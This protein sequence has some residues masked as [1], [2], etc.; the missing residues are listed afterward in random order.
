MTQYE[1]RKYQEVD[2]DAILSFM[3]EVISPDE[4]DLKVV[5]NAC[6]VFEGEKVVG[7]VSYEDAEDVGVIR[8]FIYNHYSLPDLLVNMFFSLYA[9]AKTSGV[10][11]LVALVANPYAFQLFELLGFNEVTH[12][13]DLTQVV[14]QDNATVMSISL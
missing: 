11:R 4:I 8:Y 2:K 5:Q 12:K 9:E 1:V 10:K 14:E 13:E 6:V 7:M 3:S